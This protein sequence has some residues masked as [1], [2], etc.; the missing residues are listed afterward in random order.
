MKNK[1][2]IFLLSILILVSVQGFVVHARSENTPNTAFELGEV[3]IT[4]T[5]IEDPI[6]K[7]PKNVTVITHEDIEK[8]PSTTMVDMLAKE[9]NITLRS[10]SGQDKGASVDIRGMGDTMVSSV[11]VMEDGFKLNPPDMAGPDFAS[12]PLTQIKRIEI[13]RGAGSVLYGDGA[14]GGV[15]NIITKKGDTL[16]QGLLKIHYGGYESSDTQISYQGH[17]RKF[18]GAFNAGYSDSEGYRDNGFLRK[19]DIGGR[20][21]VDLSSSLIF[22]YSHSFHQDKYGLPGPVSSENIDSDERRIETDRPEDFGEVTDHRMMGG[23]QIDFGKEGVLNLHSGY[24][25][26]DNE[27]LIGYTPLRSREEQIDTI[28]EDS[29]IFDCGYEKRYNVAN[30]EQRF[31]GGL[32]YFR[33]TYRRDEISKESQKKSRVKDWGI[34]FLNQWSLAHDLTLHGGY[35]YNRHEVDFS[36]YQFGNEEESINPRWIHHVYDVGIVYDGL[37]ST[38][39]FASY[40]TSFR[41]PNVDELAERDEDL[42][43]QKGSHMECGIRWKAGKGAELSGT[44]FRI[45]T[46]DEIYYSEDPDTN[47]QINRNYDDTTIRVGIETDFRVYPTDFLSLWGNFSYTEARFEGENTYVPLVPKTKA[48]LGGEWYIIPQL[49]LCMTGTHVGTRFDGNDVTNTMY[50]KLEA[51][52]VVDTKLIYRRKRLKFYA[53]V[54][55]IFNKKYVTSAYSENYYPMPTGNLYAGMELIF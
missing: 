12:I 15:I 43:P 46:K 49:S 10:Y 36:D 24:R 53:G 31:Q 17:T 22:S 3:V 5:R 28:N 27:Y 18:H 33:S 11:I 1:H 29:L 26:R 38:T 21:S 52:N 51:Y 42:S 20:F 32:D 45:K 50:D 35:R 55:N 47:E 41:C 23:I 30:K 19:G 2:S 48:T 40:S 34:F 6:K 7:I 16:S 39:F 44:I 4:A 14:V 8:A 37:P 25:T 9:T 13:L 54:N